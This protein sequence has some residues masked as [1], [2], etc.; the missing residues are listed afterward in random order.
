MHFYTRCDDLFYNYRFQTKSD[1]AST[2]HLNASIVIRLS[3]IKWNVKQPLSYIWMLLLLYFYILS[4]KKWNSLRAI[5]EC[6]C[7]YSFIS[8]Q[9]KSE[10]VYILYFNSVVDI[11]LSIIKWKV[12]QPIY[13]ILILW[14]TY[15]YL[16]LNEKWSSLYTI[17]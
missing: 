9:A 12:K 17:F 16:L 14:L 1:A 8:H 3:I 5:F 13:Y 11:L 6:C 4:S 2:L 15:F 7:C 10:A